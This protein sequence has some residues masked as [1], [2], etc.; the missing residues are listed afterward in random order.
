MSLYKRIY[1]LYYI[2]GL[3]LDKVKKRL[4]LEG[5][6]ISLVKLREIVKIMDVL[7]GSD[8]IQGSVLESFE[9]IKVEFNYVLERVKSLVKRAN[10]ENDG[11]LEL[12][13]LSELRSLLELGLKR[14]GELG[15]RIN[16]SEVNIHGDVN[17]VSNYNLFLSELFKMGAR[18]KD[19]AIWIERPSPE[20]LLD[21]RNKLVE[22]KDTSNDKGWRSGKGGSSS[23][24]TKELQDKV[25]EKKEKELIV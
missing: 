7:M 24:D 4:A 2:D 1:D 13:S 22:F 19:G 23:I 15:N 8:E 18:E 14:L 21:F 12:R 17:L 25:T 10:S 11:N 9:R 3:S 6:E 16:K 5:E 20:F